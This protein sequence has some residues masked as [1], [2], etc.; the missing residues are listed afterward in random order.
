MTGSARAWEC[1]VVLLQ[2][3]PERLTTDQAILCHVAAMAG[4]DTAQLEIIP[5][6]CQVMGART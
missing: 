2:D 5:I 3:Y 6:A 1:A 4:P